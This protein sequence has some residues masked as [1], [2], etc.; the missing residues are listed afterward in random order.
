[1]ATANAVRVGTRILTRDSLMLNTSQRTEV[2]PFQDIRRGVRDVG[3]K[4]TSG[5]HLRTQPVLKSFPRDQIK[6]GTCRL[7][8]RS[9]PRF[10]G[11]VPF[12]LGP[13]MKLFGPLAAREGFGLV[14]NHSP[15]KTSEFFR[16]LFS[17][18]ANRHPKRALAREVY[19][20]NQLYFC[21]A[22]THSKADSRIRR[23][24]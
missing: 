16:N 8:S 6:P 5:C 18:A 20:S 1:M 23:L 2:N 9:G 12:S 15:E 10:W 13:A 14:L 22:N 7:E 24:G 11:I 3:S 4:R 17:R 19:C 21:C